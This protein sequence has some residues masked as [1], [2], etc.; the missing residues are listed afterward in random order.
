MG[1]ATE[2]L[3]HWGDR[4][5]PQATPTCPASGGFS[6]AV[7]LRVETLSG[8]IAVR[9]WPG[10]TLPPT[11][12]LGLHRLLAHIA[13]SGVAQ[14]AVPVVS[15]DGSTLVRDQGRWWQVEPWLPGLADFHD[16]PLRS[17]LTA[18][19]DCLAAWHRA[20]ATFRAEPA[21]RRWFTTVDAAPSPAVTERLERLARWRSSHV[22]EHLLGRGGPER[23]TA[24]LVRI[25][26]L[27]PAAIDR[28]EAELLA[29]A[30]LPVPL[31]PCLR[32]VWHDH[33]LFDGDRVS[34]LIDPGASRTESVA[35]DLARLLGSLVGDDT[36]AWDAAIE[37]Y[38]HHRPLSTDERALV[39]IL[40]HSG[41]LL[42]GPAWFERLD[43]HPDLENVPEGII[44]RIEWVLGRLEQLAGSV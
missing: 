28:V 29:V 5:Q 38:E 21:A 1:T 36:A 41:S 32:D 44:R 14:V 37:A 13:S 27:V 2:I 22:A 40:D 25:R 6:G 18:A 19:I 17:R 12:L 20:A 9:G 42:A 7:V 26:D 31:Q 8:P 10:D 11:R 23:L 24:T 15:R 30:R 34:G 33:L 3:R 16:R 39:H 4:Y 35:A 43:K